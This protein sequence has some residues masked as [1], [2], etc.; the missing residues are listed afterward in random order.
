MLHK[1]S[2]VELIV[3]ADEAE[4]LSCSCAEKTAVGRFVCESM[5]G[6]QTEMVPGAS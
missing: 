3:A 2:N 4:Q 5:H 1:K 6:T